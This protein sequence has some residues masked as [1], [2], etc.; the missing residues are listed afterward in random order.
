MRASA[1]AASASCP[2]SASRGA[3][4]RSIVALMLGSLFTARRAR[5][6]SIIAREC[7]PRA[8]S[9]VAAPR[10]TPA[11]S[12]CGIGAHRSTM[13]SARS[14]SGVASSRRCCPTSACASA[15]TCSAVR[16][17]S[18]PKR[19]S[20]MPSVTT[21]HSSASGNRFA[22][23]AACPRLHVATMSRRPCRDA[24]RAPTAAMMAVTKRSSGPKLSQYGARS[25]RAPARFRSLGP[26]VRSGWMGLSAAPRSS[27]PVIP[28]AVL[29]CNHRSPRER[30]PRR[31]PRP[32][33]RRPRADAG[34]DGGHRDDERPPVTPPAGR[35]RMGRAS[36]PVTPCQGPRRRALRRY[37]VDDP[38]GLAVV[39]A[40]GLSDRLPHHAADGLPPIPSGFP[41]ALP[42]A[43]PQG[44][45]SSLPH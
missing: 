14:T 29:A 35:R 25:S 31:P 8:L 43:W 20:A 9:R 24:E 36:V 27:S 15:L 26:G 6:T 42:S 39:A 38:V 28:L 22:A 44:I 12:A 1:S 40:F 17:W 37:P 3:T 13:P 7:L 30:A 4:V 10:M 2:A 18:G 23:S 16:Q 33:R 32:L 5:S 11:A 21:K 19:C 45:P 34:A 41:T